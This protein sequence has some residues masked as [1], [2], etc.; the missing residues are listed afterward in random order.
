MVQSSICLLTLACFITKCLIDYIDTGQSLGIFF[1]LGH[2]DL[3][4]KVIT[5]WK[6]L[7]LIIY[8]TRGYMV[9]TIEAVH[10]DLD[11]AMST[12]TLNHI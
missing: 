2:S 1:N 12:M 9:G 10:W 6:W 7:Y 5:I 8:L 4:A 11:L 3:G